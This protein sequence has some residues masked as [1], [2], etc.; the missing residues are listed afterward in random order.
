MLDCFYDDRIT[1]I[2]TLQRR[3]HIEEK[4]FDE[5]ISMTDHRKANQE[6][7]NALFVIIKNDDQMMIFCSAVLDLCSR[8]KFCNE[9]VEFTRGT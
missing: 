5:I 4:L 3:I 6:M 9:L 1:T 2:D 8:D 7:L